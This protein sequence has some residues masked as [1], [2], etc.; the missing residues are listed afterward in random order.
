ML[1]HPRRA[2]TQAAFAASTPLLKSIII[3]SSHSDLFT[4]IPY[5]ILP[6]AMLGTAP[7][8]RNTAIRGEVD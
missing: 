4:I 7:A 6:K 5:V 3:D 2:H 1:Q 8:V